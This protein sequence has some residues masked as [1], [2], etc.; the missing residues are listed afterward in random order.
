MSPIASQ[1]MPERTNSY[2]FEPSTSAFAL[3][4]IN[5]WD[6]DAAASV[7]NSST[8]FMD[9][10]Y[11][12]AIRNSSVVSPQYSLGLDEVDGEGKTALHRAA[13]NKN[14]DQLKS[15]LERGAAVH[16][17]DNIGNEALHYAAK[18]KDLETVRLLVHYGANLNASGHRGNSPLHLA[19]PEQQVVDFLSQEGASTVAQ[20]ANGDTALHLAIPMQSWIGTGP[21]EAFS[22]PL[23][24]SLI[25]DSRVMNIT[26]KNGITPFHRLLAQ[27]YAMNTGIFTY[28]AKFL[29]LGA[30][31]QL[32]PPNNPS[33]FGLF[34]TNCV[35]NRIKDLYR[36]SFRVCAALKSFIEH[37]ANP[38]TQLP[39]GELFITYSISELSKPLPSY[40][41]D[42]S[43]L[44][45]LCK[46]VDTG[47]IKPNGNTIL[48]EL[49]RICGNY[50]NAAKMPLKESME[51]L[52]NR[53]AMANQR[54]S[55]G[56]TP[57]LLLFAGDVTKRKI[58]I[59]CASTLLAHGADPMLLD[60]KGDCPLSI[61]AKAFSSDELRQLLKADLDR[62]VAI[63]Q[64]PPTESN[65][66]LRFVWEEWD[67]ALQEES[68]AD[69]KGHILAPSSNALPQ[70]I[71]EKLRDAAFK[72]L[73]EKHMA[74]V[75]QLFEGEPDAIEK[76]RG[77]VS[78]I[79][80]DCRLRNWEP[81]WKYVDF[82]LTLC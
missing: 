9:I 16:I 41:C 73:A 54:N 28:I 81:G 69:V 62:R 30:S 70:S 10:G 11:S 50:G 26:N 37:G 8:N 66:S 63:A 47:P 33:P 67:L 29:S 17:T 36:P 80:R 18:S 4:N 71:D 59:D 75:K 12:P 61:A 14:T 56:Q 1:V 53:S 6:F 78:T 40:I 68:W 64:S 79:L 48:H 57:L 77:L 51:I 39:T 58:V 76:R 45:V 25:P 65:D 31:T 34:L 19:L 72:V 82:L 44:E 22:A 21:Y 46:H 7:V 60:S 3:H 38:T 24:D 20:D 42:H 27:K 43:F 52:L 74:L 13:I 35:E 23:I 32:P 5:P 2:R 55:E 15:L 49:A